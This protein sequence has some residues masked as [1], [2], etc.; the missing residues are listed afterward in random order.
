MELMLVPGSHP[1][2]LLNGF[3]CRDPIVSPANAANALKNPYLV[4]ANYDDPFRVVPYGILGPFF[5]SQ[6]IPASLIPPGLGVT[7]PAYSMPNLFRFFDF[8]QVPSRFAGTDTVLSP[9]PQTATAF[10]VDPSRPS[11]IPPENIPRRLYPPF[12]RISR[13]REPGKMNINTIANPGVWAGLVNGTT[14]TPIS[15]SPQA[16]TTVQWLKVMLSRRGSTPTIANIPAFALKPDPVP[17]LLVDPPLDTTGAPLPTYFAAPFRSYAGTYLVPTAGMRLFN[18]GL[19]KGTS[20]ALP[21]NEID[22]TLLRMDQF[23]AMSPLFSNAVS[24]NAS[25]TPTEV[26]GPSYADP[27]GNAAVFYR[28][29]HKLSGLTT[30]R[31]NVYAVWVT[32][33][34]F[35]CD[36]VPQDEGHPD[37]YRLGREAGIDT[38]DVR[39][40]RAFFIVD[41]S[42]PVGFQRGEAHNTEKAVLLRRFIE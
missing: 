36:S 9:V 3:G 13:F 39:R 5:M 12:N 21:R 40:H 31:S 38:G 19:F 20:P 18:G 23:T 15:G 4:G 30:T 28:S 16:Q 6:V 27:V 14:D 10:G 42:I 7:P 2:E 41:R 11:S 22:S 37:G 35:E 25:F 17:N 32:L 29:M 26:N 34:F 33:G 1:F 24:V 8:F